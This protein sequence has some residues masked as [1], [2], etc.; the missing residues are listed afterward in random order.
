M[1]RGENILII[2]KVWPEPGSSAAGVRMMQLINLFF[3]GNYK[4]HF[5]CSAQPTGIE[6]HLESLGVKTHAVKINDEHFDDFLKGLSPRVVMY[7]RFMTEEQF[8]WRVRNVL[9]ETLTLLD[10]EDL[11]FLRRGRQEGVRKRGFFEES[12]YYNETTQRELASILRTDLTLIISKYEMDLLMNKFQVNAAKLYY[13]PIQAEKSKEILPFEERRDVVFIGN[14]LHEPNWDAVLQLKKIWKEWEQKPKDIHLRIYGAYPPQKAYG[15]NSEREQFHI[16]GR[17]TSSKEVIAGSR[18]LIAPLRYGAGLKGK[19]IEAMQYGTPTITTSVG[20][21]GLN[22]LN[23]WGGV[24]E[25]DF[26]KWP[27]AINNLFSHKDLWEEQQQIGFKNLDKLNES[28]QAEEFIAGINGLTE[29]IKQHRQDNFLGEI[30]HYHTLR[31]TEFMSR[32]IAEK[33]KV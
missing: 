14:F 30:L 9:P 12:D 17:A 19:L 29:N 11:H 6:V 25:D 28:Y 26:S 24:V 4:I 27:A 13:L 23:L 5:A 8:G 2:G 33:N 3:A 16:V 22:F 15:L 21:E 18:L 7:D 10:T 32:W 31:S 1:M 20:A